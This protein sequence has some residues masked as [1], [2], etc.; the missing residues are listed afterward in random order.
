[1]KKIALTDENDQNSL[2]ILKILIFIFYFLNL[3]PYPQNLTP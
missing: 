1:M 3:K 2:F